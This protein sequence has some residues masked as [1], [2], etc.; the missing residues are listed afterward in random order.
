MH[1]NEPDKSL[2]NKRIDKVYLFLLAQLID[3]IGYHQICAQ[4]KQFWFQVKKRDVEWKERGGKDLCHHPQT[5]SR[6]PRRWLSPVSG[7][8]AW[9]NVREFGGFKDSCA[10]SADASTSSSYCTSCMSCSSQS[11][12]SIGQGQCCP[13]SGK[14]MWE[15]LWLPC[16][17]WE[18]QVGGRALTLS[19]TA[20]MPSTSG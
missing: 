4:N 10:R 18:Q 3:F 1:I 14:R 9:Q 8:G 12:E 2:I 7:L 19:F 16:H 6:C 5:S 20:H 13:V 11:P 17:P 15:R